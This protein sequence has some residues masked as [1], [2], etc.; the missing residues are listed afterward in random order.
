MIIQPDFPDHWKTQSLIRMTKDPAAPMMV[1]RLWAH[2]QQRKAWVFPG[3]RDEVLAAICRWQGEPAELRRVLHEA[4]FIDE[5]AGAAQ[6]TVH[7]WYEVNASL[8][9]RWAAGPKGGRPKSAKKPASNR[10]ETGHEPEQ[11][12]SA[13]ETEADNG[14]DETGA[15]PDGNRTGTDREDREDREEGGE[16]N[17]ASRARR[18]KAIR[19]RDLESVLAYGESIGLP[20]GE[21]E[22]FFDYFEANGWQQSGRKPIKDWRAALRT[23]RR[24]WADRNDGRNG[25]G[26][27]AAGPAVS[28][29]PPG[30]NPYTGG[31]EVVV[32]S[33]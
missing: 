12:R 22:G 21:C 7:E 11:N 9:Q 24:R 1:I 8:A 28:P 31:L 19:P 18:T 3:M 6:V 33:E 30:P 10:V 4:G 17:V 13:S 32:P 20:A 16:R 29:L 14:R 5:P 23:W 27:N 15:K 25:A 2:C 26:G